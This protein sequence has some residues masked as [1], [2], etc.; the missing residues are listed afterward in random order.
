MKFTIAF[1][2][3]S[4]CF[5]GRHSLPDLMVRVNHLGKAELMSRGGRGT[6]APWATG[7]DIVR[8]SLAA[9]CSW[10]AK[11]VVEGYRQ[12][13][14]FELVAARE[15]TEVDGVAKKIDPPFPLGSS[16][17]DVLQ[18]SFHQSALH[19]DFR[20]LSL[21]VDHSPAEPRA[22]FAIG[23]FDQNDPAQRLAT[24]MLTFAGQP[25]SASAH[26]TTDVVEYSTRIRNLGHLNFLYALVEDLLPHEDDTGPSVASDEPDRLKAE[27]QVVQTLMDRYGAPTPQHQAHG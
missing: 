26:I 14:R 24:L 25:A 27:I 12:V 21:R 18:S 7:Q 16:L 23:Y 3:R 8:M 6:S 9:V 2:L 1:C 19:W 5:F 22:Y 15:E 20:P 10:Q 13:S 4:F 17:E 11:D